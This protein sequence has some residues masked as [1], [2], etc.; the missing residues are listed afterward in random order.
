MRK[1]NK[2]QRSQNIIMKASDV[3]KRLLT[4]G[5]RR[6]EN[7]IGASSS[8]LPV[9]S[10]PVP[11]HPWRHLPLASSLAGCMLS[12]ISSSDT[13]LSVCHSGALS[14]P[15]FPVASVL[16][17]SI[18]L[19]ALVSSHSRSSSPV[20]PSLTRPVALLNGLLLSLGPISVPCSVFH[21]F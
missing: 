5:R 17:R 14:F 11:F 9:P 21:A 6:L 18:P 10:L 2:G 19:A 1:P 20:P 7:H 4:K 8:F 15:P 12:D 3:N 13:A 16:R